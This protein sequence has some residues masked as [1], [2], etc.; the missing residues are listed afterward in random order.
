MKAQRG[1]RHERKAVLPTLA[2]DRWAKEIC[3]KIGITL[4]N[5]VRNLS[6]DVLPRWAVT[7]EEA[8]FSTLGTVGRFAYPGVSDTVALA[9]AA[10]ATSTIGLL[11]HVLLAPVWPPQ[12]LAK[13]G[14]R[15]LVVFA[16]RNG[17][18]IARVLR[19]VGR[20]VVVTPAADHLTEELA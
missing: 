11:Y 3:V 1:A 12:L 9:A 10:G 18:E 8:G 15:V 13:P 6:A 5:Q 7:A 17:P 4:P 19:P 20:L 2:T 16:P 14:D